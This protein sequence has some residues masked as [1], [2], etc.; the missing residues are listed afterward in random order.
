L[1][2][3]T[4]WVESL[5][6]TAD[7]K[8]LIS[9]SHDH[10]VRFWDVEKGLEKVGRM[11]FPGS[12]RTIQLTP[13]DKSLIV[14]GGPKLLKIF[15]LPGRADV[16]TL[17][18]GGPIAVTLQPGDVRSLPQ[19]RPGGEI[20]VV[21]P[22]QVAMDDLPATVPSR[23]SSRTWLIAAVC[24]GLMLTMALVAGLCLRYRRRQ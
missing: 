17:W 9:S 10:S 13:N 8:T 18:G 19:E 3:H 6:F 21:M 1:A 15:E 14:G 23:S 5:V 24:L 4:H 20:A 16:A 12:T 22:P 7:G 2:G 11:T